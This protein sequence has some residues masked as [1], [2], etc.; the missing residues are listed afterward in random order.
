M[1][2]TLI[3]IPQEQLQ[4]LNEIA[5]EKSTSRSALVRTAIEEF[6]SKQS[7]PIDAFGI[8]KNNKI[9]GLKLQNQLRDEWNARF[10]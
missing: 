7:K 9:N 3:D 6:L 4:A 1:T 10:I 5:Q 8:L 2:R